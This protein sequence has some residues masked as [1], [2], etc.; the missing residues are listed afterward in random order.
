MQLDDYILDYA[1]KKEKQIPRTEEDQRAYLSQ[2]IDQGFFK[3]IDNYNSRKERLSKLFY[4]LS[5]FNSHGAYSSAYQHRYRNRVLVEAYIKG[6]LSDNVL[7]FIVGDWVENAQSN[8]YEHD[9]VKFAY[10][11]RLQY[12]QLSQKI[13]EAV[14]VYIQSLPERV[15]DKKYDTTWELAKGK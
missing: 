10:T 3:V 15:R 5:Q 11:I 4:H 2:L 13:L 9:I 6:K 14:N 12:P 8:N 1:K 7:Q